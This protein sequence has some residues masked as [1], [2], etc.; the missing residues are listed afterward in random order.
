[1]RLLIAMIASCCALTGYSQEA[2][3]APEE[4]VIEVPAAGDESSEVAVG[5]DS[6]KHEKPSDGGCGCGK[7]K[8]F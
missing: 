8:R 4:V 1:M 3:D 5:T 2:T 7:S 6:K